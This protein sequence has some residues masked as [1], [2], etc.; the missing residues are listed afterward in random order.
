MP[1]MVQVRNVPDRLHVVLRERAI[2]RGKSLS[3]YLLEELERIGR[4]L[5]LDEWLEHVHHQP[6]TRLRRGR[7]AASLREGRALR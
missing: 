6:P 2:R 4:E 5:P 7:A 3:S 1:K